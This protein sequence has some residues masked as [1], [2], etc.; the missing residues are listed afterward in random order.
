MT[1]AR[2]SHERSEWRSKGA[3]EVSQLAPF[4]LA[5]NTIIYT[6]KDPLGGPFG[7]ILKNLRKK[8]SQ[9]WKKPA[10]KIFWSWAGLELVLVLGRPQKILQ[11]I[12]AE[13]ATLV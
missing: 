1:L 8:V 4:A 3:N 12:E 6:T 10:L 9:N 7:D 11:K 2:S 13:E 5:S